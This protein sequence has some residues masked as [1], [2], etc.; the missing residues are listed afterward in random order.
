[1]AVAFT[2]CQELTNICSQIMPMSVKETCTGLQSVR[3]FVNLGSQTEKHNSQA[4]TGRIKIYRSTK[5]KSTRRSG[6]K[7]EHKWR[8][9][10]K[11][12][13]QRGREEK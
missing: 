9:N 7:R 3:S 1:M 11:H 8:M 2:S 12:G 4:L 6:K 13:K 5:L 10:R